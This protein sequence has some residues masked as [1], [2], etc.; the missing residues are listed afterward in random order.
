M[1]SPAEAYCQLAM[2]S[3]GLSATRSLHSDTRGVTYVEYV[4]L[5]SFVTIIGALAV[6]AVGVPLL[7]TFRYAQL[8]LA[9]PLP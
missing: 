4:T 6:V 5:I 2:G 1:L 8:I 3:V 9:M 7:H